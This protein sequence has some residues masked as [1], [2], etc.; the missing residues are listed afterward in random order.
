MGGR[1]GDYW[2]DA[3]IDD[4]F[5]MS[6]SVTAFAPDDNPQ[7]PNILG[8]RIAWTQSFK[9]EAVCIKGP[10]AGKVLSTVEKQYKS[11]GHWA[12]RD[13]KGCFLD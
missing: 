2:F 3:D 11:E 6:G 13:F 10:Y 5:A 9:F 8:Y 12:R 4:I 7:G 1:F